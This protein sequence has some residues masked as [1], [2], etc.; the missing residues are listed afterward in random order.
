MNATIE[1]IDAAPAPAP[2]AEPDIRHWVE[3]ALRA[4]RRDHAGP[5]AHPERE[6]SL[7]IRI[8]GEEESAAL[9][10][11]YRAKNYP[12]N[13]L[14]FDTRPPEEIRALLPAAPLGDLAICRDVV[15]RE[16]REQGKDEVAHWAHMLVHGTLHLCGMDHQNDRDAEKMESL[17]VG[18]LTSLGYPD[19]YRTADPPSQPA[20]N[21]ANT[22]HE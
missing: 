13:V 3:T 14:S 17:E 11:Q 20:I 10:C 1:L 15:A 4:Y 5:D 19:P 16:A 12:T 6:V 7:S 2:V 18:I 8:V 9:N 22:D 21:G